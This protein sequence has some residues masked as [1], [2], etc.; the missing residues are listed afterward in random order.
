MPRRLSQRKLLREKVPSSRSPASRF[1]APNNYV[2]IE[3]NSGH[4]SAPALPA[5]VAFDP[6]ETEAQREKNPL[7]RSLPQ[8]AP[9]AP[10][11]GRWA[12]RPAPYVEPS[13]MKRFTLKGNGVTTPPARPACV[14][15]RQSS[16]RPLESGIIMSGGTKKETGETRH[17]QM[18]QCNGNSRPS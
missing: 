12:D 7:E 14:C 1:A 17:S 10:N 11:V 4:R 18:L 8:A 9:E 16:W 5:S 3:S 13:A 6:V 15:H 2:A